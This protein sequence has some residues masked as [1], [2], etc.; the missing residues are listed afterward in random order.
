MIP[1]AQVIFRFRSGSSVS[2]EWA[3]DMFMMVVGHGFILPALFPGFLQESEFFTDEPW[4]GAR[5]KYDEE[6][7]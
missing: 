5:K 6:G 4:V 2:W 1:M 3:E 7:F